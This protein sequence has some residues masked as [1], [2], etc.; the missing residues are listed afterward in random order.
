MGRRYV[1]TTRRATA[2][3]VKG[4][5]FGDGKVLAVLRPG[6]LVEMWRVLQVCVDHDL[7]VIPQAADTGLTGGSGP[8][9]QGYDRDVVILSTLRIDQIHLVNDAREAVCLAGSTLYALE[10]VL[11]V[12]DREPHSVIGS[13]M[14]GAAVVSGIANNS[15]GS[16]V[17]KGP[18]FTEYALFA[19][20]NEE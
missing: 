5:R 17:R 15:G 20:V 2:A 9:D 7:I 6:S 8:G 13:S 16:Q 14:I 12:H 3:Y 18:A 1:L 10:E 11:T 4:N 19:R